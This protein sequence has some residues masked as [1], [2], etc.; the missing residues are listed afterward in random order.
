MTKPPSPTCSAHGLAA[1]PDGRC[2]LCRRAERAPRS[3]GGRVVFVA[4]G[5][6]AAAVAGAIVVKRR[7]ATPQASAEVVPIPAAPAE[8]DTEP[9]RATP[10][11]PVFPAHRRGTA[12]R[13]AAPPSEPSATGAPTASPDD[14]R[15]A[16]AAELEA[17]MARVPIRM[18]TT[19]WCPVCRRAK[20]YLIAERISFT[21]I[22]AESSPEA[23]RALRALNPRGSIPTFDIDGEVLVGFGPNRV[24]AARRNAAKRRLG[25]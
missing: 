22:D 21:E 14:E 20:A 6:L 12:R 15:R 5:V 8:D 10:R 17:A 11:S 2:V 4:L 25:R 19:S 9:P 16:R 13:P 7:P 23:R 1:G 18:Y 24:Q 3:D